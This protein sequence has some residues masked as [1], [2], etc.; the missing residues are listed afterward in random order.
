MPLE[1][2]E[3]EIEALAARA[4]AGMCRW[5]DL[6]AEFDRREGWATWGCL[7]C[8]HWVSW[9][10][11][12]SL[13]S[14]REHVRVARCLSE[15]STLHTEFAAGRLSYSKARALT[16]VA[17]AVN[18]EELLELAAHATAAQLDILVRAY[19]RASAAQAR[20][21]HRN[22]YLTWNHED[23]GSLSLHA[24]L[25]A[26]DGATVLAALEAAAER[27]RE[28]RRKDDHGDLPQMGE[29]DGSA[30]PREVGLSV[31]RAEAFVAMAVDSMRAGGVGSKPA[32]R[33]LV[34]VHVDAAELVADGEG[35]CHIR[36]GSGLR[37]ET[38]RRLACDASVV[39][40]LER[41]GEPLSVGRRTRTV[42]PAMRRAVEARDGGCRFPGCH[43]KRYVDAHH[44][45]HWAAGGETRASNLLMLCRRHHRM[46]HEDSYSIESAASGEVTFK[47]PDG[48]P[49][50]VAPAFPP[51]SVAPPLA[52]GAVGEAV[53]P[54]PLRIG[55][56]ETMH[57]DL[58]VLAMFQ[59]CEPSPRAGPETAGPVSP[60]IAPAAA[61]P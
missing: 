32:D 34:V 57:L 15:L 33:N 23:D 40:F 5:L 61:S 19:S 31:S 1:L 47:R 54:G 59:I 29:L 13:R 39:T 53:A 55:T 3:R 25:P 50:P 6:I 28:D 51:P 35:R 43:N 45:E 46:V 4:N 42:P 26:E 44:I 16:R 41:D 14:A 7:S 20:D 37:T 2:L 52:L 30:E 22:R 24:N 38:A 9:R 17:T 36:D 18:E 56:G 12:V 27:I 11:A 10:C 21:V 48:I 49:I 58:A 60:V 8:A